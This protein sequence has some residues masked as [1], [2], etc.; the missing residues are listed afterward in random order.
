MGH[1]VTGSDGHDERLHGVS[2]ASRLCGSTSNGMV[3]ALA[4]TAA[5]TAQSLDVAAHHDTGEF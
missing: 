3:D 2:T 5:T 1:L 4:V